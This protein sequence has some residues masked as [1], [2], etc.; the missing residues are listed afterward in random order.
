VLDPSGAALPGV[1]V[2]LIKSD[3]SEASAF[4]TDKQGRFAFLSL[5]PGIYN[6]Q[7]NK[8]EFKPLQ[9]SHLPVTVTETLRRRA[10]AATRNPQKCS[11]LCRPALVSDRHL[12]LGRV[13]RQRDRRLPLVTRSFKQMAGLS[14]GVIVRLLGENSVVVEQPYHNWDLE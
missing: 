4:H 3:G 11:G 8:S 6:L 10:A 1:T 9:R 14:P 7:A 13:V 12:R 2:S 5:A